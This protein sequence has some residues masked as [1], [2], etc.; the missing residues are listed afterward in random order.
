MTLTGGTVNVTLAS[1]KVA[2]R[3]LERSWRGNGA[4]IRIAAGDLTLE[5]PSGFNG[6]IDADILRVGKIE[7]SYGGLESRQKPGLTPTVVRARAGAGGASFKFTVGDGTITIRKQV[8][9]DK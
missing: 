6:D 3:I 4:V 9:S 8:T 2:F 7:D 1:G 5:L